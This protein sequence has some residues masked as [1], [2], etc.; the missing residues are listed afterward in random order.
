M[1]IYHVITGFNT[2]G[3][4][5]ML[6]DL[7]RK[8]VADGCNVTVFYFK[9]VAHLKD[10]FEKICSIRKLEF[11]F[12]GVKTFRKEIKKNPPFIVHTHLGHADLFGLFSTIGLKINGVTTFHN[13][14]YKNDFRDYCYFLLYRIGFFFH[15]QWKAIGISRSVLD[16]INKWYGL[17]A[18][19][20]KLLYNFVSDYSNMRASKDKVVDL[21]VGFVGRL[22][23]QKSVETLLNALAKLKEELSF[24]CS[25]IGDG[26]LRENL[27][28]LSRERGIENSI[29]FR[30]IVDDPRDYIQDW[31]VMV[32]P[33]N[34]EGFGIVILEAFQVGIPCIVS[35]I[36]GPKEII[37]ES[38]GGLLFQCGDVDELAK[39][40]LFASRNPDS[41]RQMGNR[42]KVFCE[43]R[44]GF[45]KYYQSLMDFYEE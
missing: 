18:P 42:G 45:E 31:D 5:K 6:L 14:W 30:G 28:E 39:K 9:E 33:S 16:H 32:L 12:G 40:L 43:E 27:Q 21:T 36:E 7:V 13:I 23:P 2:G 1:K 10:R 4:E 20:S 24:N 15:R 19:R 17:R 3:A 8:Q 26:T 11:S 29:F 37:E 41:L 35:E 34:F 38:G 44:F 25:I 22:E